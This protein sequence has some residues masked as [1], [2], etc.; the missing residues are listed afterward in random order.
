MRIKVVRLGGAARFDASFGRI[1]PKA[2]RKIILR[3]SARNPLKSPD[4]KEGMKIKARKGKL[5]K[6][7]TKVRASFKK[8]FVYVIMV[9]PLPAQAANPSGEDD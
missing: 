6:A 3:L 1:E 8:Q 5:G 2:V 4:S 9:G 7:E